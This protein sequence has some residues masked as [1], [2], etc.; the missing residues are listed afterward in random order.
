MDILQLIVL[1]R[2]LNAKRPGKTV[3]EIVRCPGLQCLSVMHQCLNRV[4]RFRPGEF[5]LVRLPALDHRNRQFLFAEIRIDIQHLDRPLLGIL[6]RGMGGVPFLPQELRRTQKRARRFLPADNRAPLI[7]HLGQI[8]V[9]MDNVGV[10]VAEQRLRCRPD[11]QPLHQ[12]FTASVCHPCRLGREPL[13]MILFLLQQALRNEQRQ[14]D[15]LHA[16]LLESRVQ[17]PLD[18]LPDRVSAGLKDHAALDRG[19]IHQF[20]LFDHIRVPLREILF[21]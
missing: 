1:I 8:T 15:I 11:R 9:G 7:V 6:R 12:F 17:K 3:A 2:I 13:Y 21:H 16:A 20:R 14:V 4:G 18:I 5:L 19:I 10:Q